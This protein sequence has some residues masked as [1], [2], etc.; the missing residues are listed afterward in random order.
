M[1]KHK[2]LRKYIF[3]NWKTQRLFFPHKL[4]SVLLIKFEVDNLHVL[5]AKAGGFWEITS[6]FM[7]QEHLKFLY[8]TFMKH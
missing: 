7:Q 6:F 3:F 4:F 2:L 5:S 1:V 8:K